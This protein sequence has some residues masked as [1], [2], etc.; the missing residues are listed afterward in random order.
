MNETT[1]PSAP[2]AKKDHVQRRKPTNWEPRSLRTRGEDRP[3]WT[4]KDQQRVATR[5]PESAGGGHGQGGRS[6]GRRAR[7]AQPATNG[8]D[9]RDTVATE[10]QEEPHEQSPKP[11][12]TEESVPAPADTHT[13]PQAD[14][15]PGDDSGPA[16]VPGEGS[17]TAT[18]P[19]PPATVGE[20][21][22]GG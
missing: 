14:P 9:D 2:A 7:D 17:T 19:V 16:E 5:A 21:A 1:K 18:Q 3:A 12:T 15:Q 10:S 11:E 20:A 8:N 13:T 6:T 22:P 4:P